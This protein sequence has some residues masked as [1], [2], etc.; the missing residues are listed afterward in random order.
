MFL[1]A[2][3]FLSRIPV[4]FD[5]HFSQQKLNDSAVYFPAVGLLIALLSGL[6]L[7]LSQVLFGSLLVSVLLSMLTSLLLTGAFHEDGLADCADGFG[8]GYEPESVL[9][10]MKDSRLGTFGAAALVSV[11]A[12]KAASLASLGSPWGIVLALCWGHVLSRGVAISVQLEL[13]Y[14]REDGKAKPLAQGLSIKAFYYSLLPMAPLVVIGM[15]S[16]LLSG[17]GVIFLILSLI[18]FRGFWI[19]YLRRRIGGYTGDT[20]GAAQQISELL[21]YLSFLV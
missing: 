18:G 20:L 5:T 7:L 3:G 15:F 13:G 12:I 2:L 10:I 9:H 11:L 4:P 21:V 14:V 16:A 8:G 17:F 1:C 6:I 19:W